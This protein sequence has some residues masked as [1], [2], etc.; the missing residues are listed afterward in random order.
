[1]LMLGSVKGCIWSWRDKP[2]MGGWDLS[3]SSFLPPPCRCV[4]SI[5]A[6]SERHL[7][8]FTAKSGTLL[9]PDVSNIHICGVLTH[10]FPNVEVCV[11][12]FVVNLSR[13]VFVFPGRRAGLG[14]NAAQR[15][16]AST[17]RAAAPKADPR[18]G[19]YP[20]GP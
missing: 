19:A 1:M 16:A 10:W 15:F 4:L 11:S 17:G 3:R 20:L 7:S 13:C 8:T 18:P 9:D 14:P 12:D 2:C 6:K 5:I